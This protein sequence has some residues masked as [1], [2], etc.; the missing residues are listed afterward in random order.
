[1]VTAANVNY[2]GSITIPGDLMRAVDLWPGEKVLVASIT[3][4]PRLETYVLKGPDGSGQIVMNGGAAHRITKGDR[5]T[6][7]AFAHTEKPIAARI[8]VCNE[9]NQIVQRRVEAPEP[10]AGADAEDRAPQL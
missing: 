6:I 2:E 5:I 9:Q 8:V 10:W 7:L 3:H 1:M 4:G